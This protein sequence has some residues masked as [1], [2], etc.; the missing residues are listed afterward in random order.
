[1]RIYYINEALLL[2]LN[3]TVKINLRLIGR[4][5]VLWLEGDEDPGFE[6]DDELLFSGG[7]DS[8]RFESQICSS[9]VFEDF[10]L[11]GFSEEEFDEI[12][13]E[14]EALPAPEVVTGEPEPEDGWRFSTFSAA[15]AAAA[16][17]FLRPIAFGYGEVCHSN[18]PS[19]GRSF[20]KSKFLESKKKLVLYIKSWIKSSTLARV[21][22]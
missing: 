3:Q 21:F 4:E 7:S 11:D 1:M 8:A 17:R 5:R 14:I 10:L 13:P 6:S 18:R 22:L 2:I 20:S 16:I 12:S 15:A 9:D 19:I